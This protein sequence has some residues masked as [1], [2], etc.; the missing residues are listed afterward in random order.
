M[1]RQISLFFIYLASVSVFWLA[2]LPKNLIHA[3]S[4]S[5]ILLILVVVLIGLI[6][7]RSDRFKQNF[8]VEIMMIFLAI[9]LSTF[10]AKWGHNQMFGLT[11]WAQK[12]ML[13]YMLYFFL[14]T[15]RIRPKEIERLMLL[16]AILYIVSFM[17]QYLAY[18]RILFNTRVQE[19]RGTVR[20]FLPGKAFVVVMYFYF[21]QLFFEKTKPHYLIFCLLTF[22][23]TILQ[24]TRSALLLLLVGTLFNLIFSKRVKSRF[25]ILFLL[26]LSIIPIFIIFQ[27]IFLNMVAVSEEQSETAEEDIRV[28]A[29]TYFLTDFN[30]GWLNY[31]IGNGESHMAS[32]YGMQVEMFKINFG[33]FQ[34]DIGL[35]G[36]YVKYGILY[37]LAVILILRK[38]LILKLEPQY[39]YFKYYIGIS[40]IGMI[41]GGIFAKED[42]FVPILALLYFIDVSEYNFKHPT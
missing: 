5:M 38:V 41:M 21:L 13:F 6:Y 28:K 25:L 37:V 34:S 40:F 18:P 16:I 11:I 2:M 39:L 23:V 7:D 30:P 29:A 8:G 14:H 22:I 24:G 4:A 15:I 27:D 20:I 35:I 42:S 9:M 1:L 32:A 12:G 36:E 10:G 19:D 31:V 3:F 26:M 33:Y 17:L